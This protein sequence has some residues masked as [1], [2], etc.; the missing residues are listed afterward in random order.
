MYL[1]HRASIERFS[2]KMKKHDDIDA[3]IVAGSVAHGL[4][5]EDH[6]Q[7]L[8]QRG[9][10]HYFETASCT[11]DGGYI[12]GNYMSLDFVANVAERKQS[13]IIRFYS[14]FEAWK[15]YIYEALR[16]QDTYL[17]QQSV[18]NDVLFGGRMILAYNETLYPFH[19]WF[20]KVLS[21]VEPEITIERVYACVMDFAD[22]GTDAIES[23]P[24]FFM[25]DSE[26]NWLQ[27]LAP[28]ADI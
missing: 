9:K 14:Q 15:W 28:I 7:D 22:G 26:L 16:N 21:R 17:I 4:V 23:W 2:E 10:A 1:H 3:V 13:N 6:Y 24:N 8:F 18:T 5:A 19:K 12:D 27:G 11:Y 20:M 25:R